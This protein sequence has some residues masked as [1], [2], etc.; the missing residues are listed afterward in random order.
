MVTITVTCYSWAPSSGDHFSN[1]ALPSGRH[2]F[3]EFTVLNV[4]LSFRILNNLPLPW[5]T[6]LALKIF[7]AL[8]IV[9]T[10]R[11][12]EQLVLALKNRVCLE[13]VVLNI[14]FLSFR[15]LNNLRL[16]WK[17]SLHWN[18]FYLSGFFSKFSLLLSSCCILNMKRLVTLKYKQRKSSNASSENNLEDCQ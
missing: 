1:V 12:F 9:F 13:Y 16:P 17:F 15:I 5:K 14:Y 11:T 10:F 18:I 2:M 7:I 4:F 6:E 3:P 8:N